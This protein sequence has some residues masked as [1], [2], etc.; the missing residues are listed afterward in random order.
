MSDLHYAMIKFDA[1]KRTLSDSIRRYLELIQRGDSTQAARQWEYLSKGFSDAS[2]TLD[3]IL[4]WLDGESGNIARIAPVRV[5]TSLKPTLESQ[6]QIYSD[7]ALLPPP[8]SATDQEHAT[9]AADLLDQLVSRVE[10]LQQKLSNATNMFSVADDHAMTAQMWIAVIFGISFVVLLFAT[11]IL[12]IFGPPKPI[13][14]FAMFILRAVLALAA[15]GFGVVLSGMLELK[16]SP[17]AS[18]AIQ[19]TSGFGL[20]LII[21]LLNPPQLIASKKSKLPVASKKPRSRQL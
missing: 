16:V 2:G 4:Q 15:A 21:Y 9:K 5:A 3:T 10:N 14:D 8:V 18:F 19:A 12:L 1:S 13:P 17:T 11:A 20:F 6:R 7:L